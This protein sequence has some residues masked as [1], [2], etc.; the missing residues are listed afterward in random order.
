MLNLFTSHVRDAFSRYCIRSFLEFARRDEY[1]KMYNMTQ[2][3]VQL[4]EPEEGVSP[5]DSRRRPDQ[6]EMELGRWDEANRLK[7][8][9][10]E[11]QRARRRKR[12]AEA[13]AAAAAGRSFGPYEPVWFRRENDEQTGNAIY[14]YTGEY[15]PCK[16]KQDWNR[17]PNIFYLDEPTSY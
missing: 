2:L 16:D 1:E 11:N 12:E 10:E 9:L 6:R 5:T 15:W 13:E 7:N 4:N 8:I 14:A 3:A 17:C